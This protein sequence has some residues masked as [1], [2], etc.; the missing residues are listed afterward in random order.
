VTQNKNKHK[1]KSVCPLFSAPPYR[2]GIFRREVHKWGKKMGV[3]IR[4]FYTK[5]TKNIP[6]GYYMASKK[7]IYL[8]A[9]LSKKCTLQ[10]LF[11]EYMHHL[12]VKNRLWL[13][14]HVG[15]LGTPEECF[16]IENYIDRAAKKLW[17]LVVDNTKLGKYELTYCSKHK[18]HSLGF[19]R[20]F[21]RGCAP[22]SYQYDHKNYYQRLC[23]AVFDSHSVLS[24]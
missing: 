15:G 5:P 12:A 23:Q 21:R 6:E 17:N 2:K 18:K 11:H 13:S 20:N 1:K 8:C 4:F 10:T 19:L 3:K 7:T 22:L 9:F 14:Y 16:I 24:Q